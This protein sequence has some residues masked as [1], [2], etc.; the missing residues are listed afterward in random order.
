M[1][2]HQEHNV[3][4]PPSGLQSGNVAKPIDLDLMVSPMG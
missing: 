3:Y 1:V 4:I 2:S